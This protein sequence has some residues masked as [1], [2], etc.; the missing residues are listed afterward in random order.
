VWEESPYSESEEGEF[1]GGRR[2]G[3]PGDEE[4]KVFRESA[5]ADEGF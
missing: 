3:A 1:G 5:D 4:G 2:D